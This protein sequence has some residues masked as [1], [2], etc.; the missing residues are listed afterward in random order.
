MKAVVSMLVVACAAAAAVET[1]QTASPPVVSCDSAAMFTTP[2]K[3]GSGERVLFGRVAVPGRSLPQLAAA[4]PPWR[5]WRKAGLLVK[6]GTGE[7]TISVPKSWRDRVAISWGD[8]G[9]V[10]A[11]RIVSC[12]RPPNR[13]NVYTGGFYLRD[14]A[15]VPLV[16]RLGTRSATVRFGVGRSGP[17]K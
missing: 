3:P 2:Q 12:S 4:N 10:P 17:A 14:P 11:V 8:S 16:V 5:Y 6:A 9:V 13:W 15:C 1:S 7:V